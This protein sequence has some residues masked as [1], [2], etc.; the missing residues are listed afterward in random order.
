M[1]AIGASGLYSLGVA[2]QAMEA[3]KAPHE[4]HL[5]LALA[6]GLVKRGRWLFGTGM[7]MLGWPLQVL[8]VHLAPLVIVQPAMAVGLVVLLFAGERM[9]GE[10]G[11]RYE[12]VAMAAIILGVIGAGLCAPPPSN[13]HTTERLEIVLP[14]AALGAA[15]LLP[16]LLKPFGRNWPDLT[17]VCA[18]LA[19]GW[20]GV[21][22]KLAS[23][24]LFNGFLLVALAWGVSTAVASGVGT[25]SEMSAL[26]SRPAILVAPV[27]F[28]TQTVIPVVL[29]PTILEEHF[30][31]TPAGGIPLA[32]SLAVLIAGAGALARSPLLLALM[33]PQEV[34]DWSDSTARPSEA[35]RATSPS[36]QA[37]E[38]GEPLSE[39]TST[40]PARIPR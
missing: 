34:S 36:S 38:A 11:G 18:G 39:T 13:T 31:S 26:Q 9:L 21:A 25:L 27:V 2:F 12:H 32:L 19:F 35:S 8:A 23:D 24:D 14:L 40:S 1:A 7:S 6:W 4:E 3:R 29:A 5:R 10:R 28:V 20:S 37:T 33:E 17:I 16:Y 15:S 22:T 30:T